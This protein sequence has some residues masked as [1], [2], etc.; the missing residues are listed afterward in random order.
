MT[1]NIT[2]IYRELS[3]LLNAVDE[4][5]NRGIPREQI[6]WRSDDRR[7]RVVIPA[8]SEP[9]VNE[10]LLRHRPAGLSGSSGRIFGGFEEHWAPGANAACRPGAA[11]R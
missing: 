7:V 6:H 10:A 4:L 1:L 3:A 8:A 9:E 11:S 5:I 2:A